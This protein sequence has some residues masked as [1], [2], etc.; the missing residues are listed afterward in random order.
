MFY[1]AFLNACLRLFLLTSNHLLFCADECSWTQLE[2]KGN[3][4]S[5]RHGHLAVALDKKIFIHGGM[6]EAEIY[7][8]LHVLDLGMPCGLH[9]NFY[10]SIVE[11]GDYLV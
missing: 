1:A 3:A 7:S 5:P 6:A 8:D 2:C 10:V 9:G 11:T 4:P